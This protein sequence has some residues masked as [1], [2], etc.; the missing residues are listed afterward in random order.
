MCFTSSV[1]CSYWTE[2]RQHKHA[3]VLATETVS[4]IGI[5]PVGGKRKATGKMPALLC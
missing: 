4:R 3:D 5:L 1:T 2:W